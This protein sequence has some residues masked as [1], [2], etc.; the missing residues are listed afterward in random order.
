MS[1]LRPSLL[2]ISRNPDAHGVRRLLAAGSTLGKC[3]LLD[4][5]AI[6]LGVENGSLIAW[7]DGAGKFDLSTVVVLPRIGSTSTEYSLAVLEHLEAAGAKVLN[8]A[9]GVGRLH[10]VTDEQRPVDHLF[11]GACLFLGIGWFLSFLLALG[12]YLP[13]KPP[14]HALRNTKPPLNSPEG[15][16]VIGVC[17]I[18]GLWML[19]RSARLG[20]KGSDE[21]NSGQQ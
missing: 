2:L 6:R 3:L 21:G 5:H 11:G 13:A 17:F 19:V 8:P 9:A 18:L 16:M 14:A 10:A 4:P 1:S 12:P 7:T 20:R 15:R